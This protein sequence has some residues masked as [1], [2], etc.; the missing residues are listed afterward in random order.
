MDEITKSIEENHRDAFGI[1][2]HF[3]SFS[4]L[5]LTILILFISKLN[6]QY[7]QKLLY[8]LGLDIVIRIIKLYTYHIQDSYIKELFLTIFTCC[9]FYL[10]L[11]FFNT[12]LSNLD[13]NLMQNETGNSEFVVF[14][15]L[16]FFL[17]F[18]I[19]K[20]YFYESKTFCFSKCIIL[21]LC[22]FYFYKYLSNKYKDYMENQK[23]KAQSFMVLSILTNMPRLAF[24]CFNGKIFLKLIVL[25]FQNK[26]LLS[27][28][29]MAQIALNES[30]KYSIFLILASL[31]YIWS[32]DFVD[33]NKENETYA[34]TV[35]QAID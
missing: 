1:I 17:I 21:F 29:D 15:A 28:L 6:M 9:Q 11:T 31:L 14:T 33:I 34:V 22:L 24:Y 30:A 4:D 13:S 7:I 2:Q 25:F 8:L 20:L 27:Y 23:G 10:I 18:P 12:A 26:L 16:F 35:N 32:F 3:F 19:E 5:L